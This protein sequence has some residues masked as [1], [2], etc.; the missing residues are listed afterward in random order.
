MSAQ[1]ENKLRREK[2]EADWARPVGGAWVRGIKTMATGHVQDWGLEA[3]DRQPA[4]LR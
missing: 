1:L 4:W 3:W 2:R